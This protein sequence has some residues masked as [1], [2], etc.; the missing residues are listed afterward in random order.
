MVTPT[1]NVLKI[2]TSL[3]RC[4][5]SCVE[6]KTGITKSIVVVAGGPMRRSIDLSCGLFLVAVLASG[7]SVFAHG[8]GGH[9]GGGHGGGGH[10]GGGHMGGGGH[11][12]GFSGGF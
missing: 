6:L 7:S 4:Q 3:V 12:G 8:G 5:N 2:A 1:Q 11:H 10:G 9:G